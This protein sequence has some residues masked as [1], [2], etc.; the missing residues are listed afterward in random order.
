MPVE[1]APQLVDLYKLAVEMAD[2]VSAR[3]AGA[4]AFFISVQSAVVATL[5]FLAARRPPPPD[6]VLL[7]VAGAG[8]L[9]AAVWFTLLRAYRLLNRA[10]FE[11]ILEL[12]KQLPA[13]IFTD[14]WAV[15]KQ[16]PV[17][18]WGGRYVELGSVERL[19]PLL[20][21]GLNLVT[22]IYLVTL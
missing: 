5:G 20:F 11:V 19:A 8:V 21:A 3:R 13:Q 6:G 14:E 16:D 17:K 1:P 18:R 4:N 15:L 2:R 7:A 12:E 9:G 22:G 10:K